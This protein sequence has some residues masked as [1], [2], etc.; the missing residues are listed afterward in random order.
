MV[1]PRGRKPCLIVLKTMPKKRGLLL[2]ISFLYPN[3]KSWLQYIAMIVL[4]NHDYHDSVHDQLGSFTKWAHIDHPN[5]PRSFAHRSL[6]KGRRISSRCLRRLGEWV[7]ADR[8]TALR[9]GP[10]WWFSYSMG[11][12]TSSSLLVIW[13]TPNFEITRMRWYVMPT[14]GSFSRKKEHCGSSGHHVF[15]NCWPIPKL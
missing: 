15:D 13:G 1:N 9:C 6:W 14:S 10:R 7:R 4:H 5:F 2:T 11:A 8:S 3:E 12:P